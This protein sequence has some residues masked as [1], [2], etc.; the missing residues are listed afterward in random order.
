MHATWRPEPGDILDGVYRL[1]ASLGLGEVGERFDAVDVRDDS[2]VRVTCLHPSLFRGAHRGPNTLRIQRARAYAHG[3]VV[4]V[5]D[6]VLSGDAFYVVTERPSGMPL[7]RWVLG[8]WTLAV[9]D[10]LGRCQVPGC[11]EVSVEVESGHQQWRAEGRFRREGLVS[12]RFVPP[13]VWCG[14]KLRTD[15][16]CWDE[17]ESE[18]TSA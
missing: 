15:V 12:G 1:E 11:F 9:R 14:G 18:A 7:E 2:P 6:V 4:G 17:V 16:G 8:P 5:R 13:V 10:P 3:Y